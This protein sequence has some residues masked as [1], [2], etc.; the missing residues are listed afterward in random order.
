VVRLGRTRGARTIRCTERTRG[1]RAGAT[2]AGAAAFDQGPWQAGPNLRD[3]LYALRALGGCDASA[4]AFTVVGRF[5]ELR[6]PAW[7]VVAHGLAAA[8]P[9]L[10]FLVVILVVA[11]ARRDRRAWRF[12]WALRGH[13]PTPPTV[14]A[15]T[16]LA[17]TV[18]LFA[19][20]ATGATRISNRYPLPST[21]VDL[22]ARLAGA[23]TAFLD[24]AG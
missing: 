13:R 22:P 15:M 16:G 2:R 6:P 7:P 21:R 3:C 23:C 5:Q 19:L 1:A 4:A 9:A 20:R 18:A 10:I 11:V 24:K 14:L 12:F 17:V 8:T